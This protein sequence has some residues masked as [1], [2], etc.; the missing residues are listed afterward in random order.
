MY[1]GLIVLKL[2]WKVSNAILEIVKVLTIFR[3]YLL[4]VETGWKIYERFLCFLI[5][6]SSNFNGFLLVNIL[7]NAYGLHKTWRIKFSLS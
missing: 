3:E 2:N 1:R 5:K 7:V 4:L 6:K